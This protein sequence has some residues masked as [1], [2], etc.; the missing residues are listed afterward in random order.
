VRQLKP[1]AWVEFVLAADARERLKLL[2]VSAVR[3]QYL[4]VNRNGI[5]SGEYGAAELAELIRSGRAHLLE[6]SGLVDRALNAI[7]RKLRGGKAAS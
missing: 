1:G 4:F 3:S 2:W 5:K 7:V 6:E